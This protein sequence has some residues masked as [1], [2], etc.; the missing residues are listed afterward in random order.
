M[1]PPAAATDPVQSVRI[2]MTLTRRFGALLGTGSA[3][4]DTLELAIG[5]A[6]QLYPEI[7]R[8]LDEA[9]AALVARGRDVAAYDDVRRDEL[10][11]LGVTDVVGVTQVD[12]A[13][14]IGGRLRVVNNAKGAVFN[15]D[16]HYRATAA[17][18]A[19]A[20]A[21]PEVDWKALARA[22]DA[23]IAAVGSL[24]T[25]K[26]RGLAKA[27]ALVAALVG[28]SVLVYRL[29][30]D[31]GAAPVLEEGPV[32][33]TAARA[34]LPRSRG[35]TD[36]LRARVA[37]REARMSELRASY[38][39]TCNRSVVP[40]LA[41]LLRENMQH[42]AATKLE[43]EPCTIARP[44]C[45]DVRTAITARLAAELWLTR[46]DGWRI[47]CQGMAVLRAGTVAPGLAV[48][49]TGR[50]ADGAWRTMRGVVSPDG[51][52]DDVAFAPAA[53]AAWLV[54]VIDLDGDGGDELV[55]A[56]KD[57]VVAAR[58]TPT[59]FADVAGPVLRGRCTADL[60]IEAD[61]RAGRK[62]EQRYLVLRVPAGVTGK[63]CLAPGA[64]YY[65]IVDGRLAEI[66]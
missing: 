66:E 47:D 35:E 3:N 15:A 25:G 14:L 36:A 32:R 52:R 60:N 1:S 26:W 13:A 38:E 51:A 6:Q 62:G 19:L 65:A 30:M 34:D 37:A 7:W 28:T 31:G 50:A 22:E 8:H 11:H 61:F 39:T 18:R 16:G 57:T 20:T 9:R 29:V 5:E 2:A 58:V 56:D 41:A 40:E 55:L 59:G 49:F 54:G 48:V 21:M 43:T 64:H 42:S 10:G 44:S 46:D 23:Q 33:D 17:C 63:R 53:P 12:Y 45:E 27:A 24:H 4:T